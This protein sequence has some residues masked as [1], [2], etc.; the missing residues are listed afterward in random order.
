MSRS[1]ICAG[2]SFDASRAAANPILEFFNFLSI[3]AGRGVD[4]SS[5]KVRL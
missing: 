3:Q 2:V 5:S 1:A 4:R